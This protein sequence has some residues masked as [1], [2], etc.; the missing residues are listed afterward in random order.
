MEGPRPLNRQAG[1]TRQKP[2][3][4]KACGQRQNMT[5]VSRES[6]LSHH[7]VTET[8]VRQE[9]K[10]QSLIQAKI[11]LAA[12][13]NHRLR[14]IGQ[15]AGLRKLRLADSRRQSAGM[16]SPRRGQQILPPNLNED[17]GGPRRLPI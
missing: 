3:S 6:G 9:A 17:T 12:S 11:N 2:I 8:A 4:T 10:E 1:L 13:I 5:A 16:A 14:R 15:M 7:T